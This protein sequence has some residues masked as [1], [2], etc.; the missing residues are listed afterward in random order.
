MNVDCFLTDVALNHFLHHCF[1]IESATIAQKLGL[2]CA[3][4]PA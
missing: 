1:V 3:T 2:C 4:L